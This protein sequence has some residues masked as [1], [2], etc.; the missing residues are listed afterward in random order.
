MAVS[1][2]GHHPGIV[3]TSFGTATVDGMMTPGEWDAAATVEFS[4]NIPANDGGGTT[5]A[6]L[7]VMNDGTSL[8]LGVRIK[9][10]SFGGATSAFFEIDN[11][12]DGER[13]ERDDVFGMNVGIFSPPDFVDGF[14]TFQPPCPMNSLCGLL[15]L[16]FG[17]TSDG[18]SAASNDGEYTIL[19]MAHP[20]NSGDPYDVALAA[21]DR[22][23]VALFL[24]LFALNPSCGSCFADF[25]DTFF[26]S[27]NAAGFGDL[28]VA[29]T[30]SLTVQMLG[31][32]IGT[33]TSSVGLIDCGLVCDDIYGPGT[34]V[35]L[36]AAPARGS[37]FA[38]WNGCDSLVDQLCIVN[39]DAERAV[40]AIF[41]TPL[42]LSRQ[43]YPD[44][45]VGVVYNSDLSINGGLAPYSVSLIKGA[46]PPGL[47]IGS[48]KITGIPTEPGNNRF[49]L[50]VTD[51]RG[52]SVTRPFKIKV[53]KAID[54][55]TT[56]LKSGSIGGR[57]TA[58]LRVTGGQ[59]PYTWSLIG[60]LLPAGLT[61]DRA[62]GKL[63]GVPSLAG[64]TDL[65]IQVTDHVGGVSQKTLTLSVN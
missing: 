12:H 28:V 13:D 3:L 38:G 56:S 17:G 9:R 64:S 18:N 41:V 51:Q 7:Y 63:S 44:A 4:A 39:V 65:I 15:D 2:N 8:Y 11:N 45:E 14:R 57:Y 50:Q 5:P 27:S 16:D 52:V 30:F 32:G 47:S 40:E 31:G 29:P 59:K 22:I 54:I 37:I 24:R 53:L 42:V 19:E 23:G 36:S 62:K 58:D 35:S 48:P 10:S 33:V 1:V 49:T 60:G 25:A 34:A 21:G 43:G 20:F 26:P 55:V 46:L 61:F 6:T